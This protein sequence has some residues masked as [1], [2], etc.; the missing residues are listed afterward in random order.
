M[1]GQREGSARGFTPSLTPPRQGEGDSVAPKGEVALLAD[2]FNTYFEPENLRDAVE[3]LGRLGYRVALLRPVEGRRSLCCGRTFLS[4][5]LVEEA[6][7]EA[8]RVLAAATP[9]LE[10]GI[11]IVGLEP[12]CLLTLRDEFISVLPGKATEHL[13]SHALLFEEFIAREEAAGRIARPVARHR[14]KVLLHGH[15]HQKAFAAMGAVGQTLALVEGVEVETV[16]SSCC[17][18]AGAFGYG[19]DTHAVSLAMGE[20]SLLPAVRRANPDTI[21]AAD[22]FSC[23]HQICDGTGRAPL[24]VARILRQAMTGQATATSA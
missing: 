19:V 14:R 9:Y 21:V 16:D 6:R 22:G 17:G 10:R 7:A 3:V 15:C 1:G 11:P 20:L 5:G 18:M 12:S 4:A 24:H 8:R 13:A 23:R 2:T